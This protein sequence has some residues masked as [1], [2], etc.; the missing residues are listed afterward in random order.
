MNVIHLI[1]GRGPTGPAAAALTDVKAL[2]VAGH[3]AYLAT[4]DAPALVQACQAEGV[5]HLGG[6][7]LGRGALRLLS[8]PR[9]ARRLRALIRELSIDVVHVHRSDDQFLAASAVNRQMTTRLVRTW[10]RA[11]RALFA[12]LI[13][14]VDACLCVS[15]AHAE[16]LHAAGVPCC[17]FIQTAVDTAVFRPAV[18]QA[19]SLPTDAGK[20]PALLAHIG[21]WKRDRQGRD[22][23]QRAALDVFQRLPRELPWQGVL[24]GRGEMAAELRRE[25]YLAR[26][27][28]EERVQLLDFPQQSPAEFARLLGTFSLGLVFAAGSDGA[29]RAGVELLACGAALLVADLPG[30][31]E[32]AED[33]SCALRLP[34]DDAEAWAKAIRELLEQPEQLAAMRQAARRRAEQTH[35][36]KTR[37]EA[38]VALY[39]RV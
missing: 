10:H 12:K 37:G 18:A 23:G 5:P 31:R 29:S 9:D 6:F 20:M 28:P 4:A 35:G 15:R 27:L 36:L 38:L 11:P 24:L 8:L 16:T 32:L 21:R 13:S 14:R 33:D 3:K 26:K 1:T 19:S 34:P 22:R 17:E 7:K 25:A 39:S 30:L 2:S